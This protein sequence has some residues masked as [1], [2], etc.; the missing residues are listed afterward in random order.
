M[1][2]LIRNLEMNILYSV[3]QIRHLMITGKLTNLVSTAFCLFTFFMIFDIS[4]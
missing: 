1:Y 3:I 4:K 2:V